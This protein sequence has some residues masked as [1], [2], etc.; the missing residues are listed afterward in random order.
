LLENTAVTS[1]C[2]KANN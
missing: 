1:L 2:T